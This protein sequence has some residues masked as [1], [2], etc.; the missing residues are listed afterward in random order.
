MVRPNER[1]KRSD[2]RSGVTAFFF[3]AGTLGAEL[4]RSSEAMADTGLG[5][6]MAAPDELTVRYDQI[7]LD[8]RARTS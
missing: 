5:A 2:N 4:D 6:L 1:A 3:H 8:T 7:Q